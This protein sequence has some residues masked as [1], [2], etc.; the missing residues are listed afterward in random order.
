[1]DEPRTEQLASVEC[2]VGQN[3]EAKAFGIGLMSSN[4]L[5]Y[6]LGSLFISCMATVPLELEL[7]KAPPIAPATAEDAELAPLRSSDTDEFV[8]DFPQLVRVINA[9]ARVDILI[10]VLNALIKFSPRLMRPFT[11]AMNPLSR[12]FREIAIA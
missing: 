5:A 11:A 6:F 9:T 7:D 10:E 12:C 2:Q 4:K 1:M 3:P 8:L